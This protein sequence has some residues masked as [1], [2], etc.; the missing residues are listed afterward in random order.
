MPIVY[1]LDFAPSHYYYENKVWESQAF[2]DTGFCAEGFEQYMSIVGDRD[3]SKTMTFIMQRF[4]KQFKLDTGFYGQNYLPERGVDDRLFTRGHAWVLEGLLAVYRAT[5]ERYYL[6]E[7]KDLCYRLIEQQQPGGEWNYLLGYGV[8]DKRIYES[9]RK[10]LAWCEDHMNQEP[11]PGY[12]G[13][14]AASLSSGI[15]GLPFLNVATGY[16]NAY[17]IL[18]SNRPT[19]HDPYVHSETDPKWSA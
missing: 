6:E 15:T 12:G 17:Y 13:I 18:A 10:A 3:Y 7:E 2:V 5:K 11:G 16:A 4:M 9:A 19:K 14:I 8:P 1:A